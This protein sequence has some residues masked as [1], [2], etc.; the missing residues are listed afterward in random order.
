MRAV[1]G[2]RQTYEVFF[3]SS[4]EYLIFAKWNSSAYTFYI[5]CICTRKARVTSCVMKLGRYVILDD[6]A[7]YVTFHELNGRIKITKIIITPHNESFSRLC[8]SAKGSA[9][10]VYFQRLDLSEVAMTPSFQN[11]E[12]M[13]LILS[14]LQSTWTL[15]KSSKGGKWNYEIMNYE[16]VFA[17]LGRDWRRVRRT[18]QQ[19]GRT[20]TTESEDWARSL[21]RHNWREISQT[22]EHTDALMGQKNKIAK[23]PRVAKAQVKHEPEE[24]NKSPSSKSAMKK[25]AIHG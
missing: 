4:G 10:F 16:F 21:K 25:D 15:H 8:S 7:N 18:L 12:K 9:T 19:N 22:L 14:N 11:P 20:P 13:S 24:E 3:F 23:F 6:G 17:W 1:Y 2:F 5:T